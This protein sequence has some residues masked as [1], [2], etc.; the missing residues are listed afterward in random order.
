MNSNT[1]FKKILKRG[2]LGNL[3]SRNTRFR[4][5]WTHKTSYWLHLKKILVVVFH[6]LK[7]T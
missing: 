7:Y 1:K 2:N 4:F 3:K 5:C 6:V